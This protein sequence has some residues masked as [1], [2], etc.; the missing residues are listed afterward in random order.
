VPQCTTR[1]ACRTQTLL[2]SQTIPAL[3]WLRTLHSHLLF[4]DKWD[5]VRVEG[6]HHFV[7]VVQSQWQTV[8]GIPPFPQLHMLSHVEGFTQQYGE[9]GAFGEAR[10][11]SCHAEMGLKIQRHHYN[12]G[13]NLGEKLRRSLADVSLIRIQPV[14]AEVER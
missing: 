3:R 1:T 12:V 9:L 4:V 10:I 5:A 14:L 8:T 13:A 2:R 6:W 11:E 7:S